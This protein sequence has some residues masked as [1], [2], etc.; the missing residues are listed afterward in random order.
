MWRRGFNLPMVIYLLT[1]YLAVIE[2][3]FFVLEPLL[4]N[5]SNEMWRYHTHRR[6]IDDLELP[7][8]FSVHV[9]TRVHGWET[10]LAT[11]P[12]GGPALIS[13]THDID[14]RVSTIHPHSIRL[15]LRL[16]LHLERLRQY[17]V[18]S[19]IVS[20][21]SRAATIGADSIVIIVTWN[22]TFWSG[23]RS[24]LRMMKGGRLPATKLM[25]RDGSAYFLVLLI[26]QVISITSN[27]KGH[28]LTIWLVWP[29]F[30]QVFTVILLSRLML[31]LRRKLCHDDDRD[32][33]APTPSN[34]EFMF[35]VS[36]VFANLDAPRG[37]SPSTHPGCPVTDDSTPYP[38]SPSHACGLS[39]CHVRDE[40][41]LVCPENCF[42]LT[43][44]HWKE[45]SGGQ[46]ETP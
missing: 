12:A 43:E 8:V 18:Q 39:N 17:V 21:I 37:P 25:L 33:P 31:N 30:D 26:I 44:R 29:Y 27:L 1:R 14:D 9:F 38:I 34:V 32:E 7:L 4:W 15:S 42:E 45:L 10:R 2:R 22:E 19:R 20:I 11:L 23:R 40:D 24:D 5:V 13:E 36:N 35:S 6:R 16:R 46:W 28:S 3:V 41:A